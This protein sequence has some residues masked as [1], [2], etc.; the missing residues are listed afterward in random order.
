MEERKI[1]NISILG[2]KSVGKTAFVQKW[3]DPDKPLH[4]L[5]LQCQDSCLVQF[6]TNHGGF[7][8]IIKDNCTEYDG[9]VVLYDMSQPDGLEQGTKLYQ[10]SSMSGK[11][12]VLCGN[13]LDLVTE[14]V[15]SARRSTHAMKPIKLSVSTGYNLEKPIHKLLMQ[16]TGLNDLVFTGT[17]VTGKLKDLVNFG[18]DNYVVALNDVI[19]KLDLSSKVSYMTASDV[20][21]NIEHVADLPITPRE[22][23]S[24]SDAS[25][26]HHKQPEKSSGLAKATVNRK[27][28][29]SNSSKKSDKTSDKKSD[30]KSNSGKKRVYVFVHVSTGRNSGDVHMVRAKSHKQCYHKI[31]RNFERYRPILEW[32]FK[33]ELAVTDNDPEPYIRNILEKKGYE[34]LFVAIPHLDHFN[35]VF[36]GWCHY[37][38][39][40][41]LIS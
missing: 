31:M 15:S 30:K 29:T 34:Y 6:H 35:R 33:Y 24:E 8:V 39:D 22:E 21:K 27:R 3:H 41:N 26:R 28:K 23:S 37:I 2:L 9:A 38:Y 14:L 25:A 7:T 32:A 10:F 20:R 5:N 17:P 13:K 40:L 36:G 1:F 4:E 11:P 12:N 18:A 16:L 19:P